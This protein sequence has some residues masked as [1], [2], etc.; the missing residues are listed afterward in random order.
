MGNCPTIY[1]DIDYA[2]V[3]VVSIICPDEHVN[4]IKNNKEI[5]EKELVITELEIQKP[6]ITQQLTIEEEE[7]LDILIH[8]FTPT[9]TKVNEIIPDYITNTNKKEDNINPDYITNT[10]LLVTL[11]VQ[12]PENTIDEEFVFV[13]NII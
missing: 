11:Q 5:L 6:I 9:N 4:I 7:K 8:V 13:D 3:M 2:I 1:E 12:E 10:K